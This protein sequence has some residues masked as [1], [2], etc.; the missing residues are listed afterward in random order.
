MSED[1]SRL[2]TDELTHEA[3]L[4]R[5]RHYG[6]VVTYSP[7]AFFPLTMLCRDRCG[8]CT[9]A[10]APAKLT[11]PYMSLD[12]VRA[13]AIS[14]KE[15]GCIEALFT[16]GE[17]PEDRYSSARTFLDQV[18][19]PSTVA[20]LHAAMNLVLNEVGLLPHPNAGAISRDDLALLRTASVSQG[21]MIESLR[22]DLRAHD[23]APDKD[24]QR[25][26]ATLDFAGE[27]AIP[28]TTGIL[29]G[30]GEAED[31][32]INALEAIAAS[33]RRYGH[34][35]EVIVQNFLP[36]AGTAM[37]KASPPSTDEFVRAIACARLILPPEVSIQAPPNLIDDTLILLNSGVDDLGGISPLTIDHVN[38][39][40]PWPHLETLRTQMLH[41]GYELTPRLPVHA[42]F[43]SQPRFFDERVYP[44]VLQAID[45]SGLAREDAWVSG[46]ATDHMA[47][48]SHAITTGFDA[49]LEE[50]FSGVESG[51]LAEEK[52]LEIL[53]AARGNRLL[54]VLEFADHLRTR[55]VGDRVT[56]VMN[57]NINY[58]NICTFKCRFCAFSKG[59]LSLNLRGNPY[60][61]SQEEIADKVREAREVGATE[62]CLQGG[63]HP[64]FDG[65]F[66]LEVVKSVKAAVPEMH[67][68]AFSALEIWEGS[69][70]L[71]LGLEEYLTLLKDAGLRTLP[72]TAAEILDDSVRSIICPDK[73]SSSQWL[74]VHETAHEVGLRSNITIMFGSV[75]QPK[76]WIQHI[77]TTRSVQQRTHGFTEFVP[78]PFV[79]MASPIYLQG[80][81]RKGPTLRES[82]LMHAVGRIAYFSL[83]DNVQASWV[84]MGP[85]GARQLLQCGANDLGGTL[86]EENISHAAGSEHGR[87]LGVAD[88]KEIASSIG[89]PLHQRNTLYEI[90]STAPTD[91]PSPPLSQPQSTS[92][93]I[94]LIGRHGDR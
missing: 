68:H 56:F 83:I 11:S 37:A 2:T 31:D 5:S 89:R 17:A 87:A 60:L 71:S 63:I 64:T 16:L 91:Q 1:L 33:H 62:V 70:R 43:T 44:L 8:Y 84:K 54:K 85:E 29:I 34:I 66:Y 49:D 67:V 73:I 27:L 92:Q 55:A 40:R 14:A 9:F 22:S 32:R 46:G 93:P 57:R 21:M 23:R 25:R 45:A 53:F 77:L 74:E 90:L 15:L 39:E 81:S 94:T 18:E 26:L 50:I 75:E 86:M 20:Y 79:H 59:P 7:K 35:Q 58:T 42:Q 65:H 12:E 4:R 13:L 36:K 72:G 28:F 52:E 19:Q 24:P 38:P 82:L 10:K 51:Q 80:R 78:L 3:R 30:I 61:L 88:L 47:E 48:R 6:S 69:R 76:S 41:H